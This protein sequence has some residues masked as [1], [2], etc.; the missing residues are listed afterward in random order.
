MDRGSSAQASGAHSSWRNVNHSANAPIGCGSRLGSWPMRKHA[1]SSG[2]I[3][4]L[5]PIAGWMEGQQGDEVGDVW[6]GMEA[7]TIMLNYSP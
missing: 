4:G 6:Q 7:L 3:M 1:K 2:A 5:S